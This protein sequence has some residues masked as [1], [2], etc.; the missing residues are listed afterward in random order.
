MIITTSDVVPGRQTG[1]VLGV[2][3]GASMQGLVTILSSFTDPRRVEQ[4]L[5]DTREVE[6]KALAEMTERAEELGADAI[7]GLRVVPTAYEYDNAFKYHCL[8]Y[9]TAVKLG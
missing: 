7:M 5:A 4:M 3:R 8:V 1:E 9:G 6:E 2:V